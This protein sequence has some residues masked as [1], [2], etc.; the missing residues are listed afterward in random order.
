MRLQAFWTAAAAL[1]HDRIAAAPAG[2]RYF[3]ISSRIKGCLFSWITTASPGAASRFQISARMRAIKSPFDN[4]ETG[5]CIS[6]MLTRATL[7]ASN[8]Q[9]KN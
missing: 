9:L 7:Y 1:H 8:Y 3:P 4:I 6:R 2:N 5:I